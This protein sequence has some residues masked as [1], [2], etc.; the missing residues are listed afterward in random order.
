MEGGCDDEE[1]IAG[2][3]SLFIQQLVVHMIDGDA[4]R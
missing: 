3:W 2:R 4:K 1:E